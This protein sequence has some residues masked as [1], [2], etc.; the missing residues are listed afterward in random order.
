MIHIVIELL[1]L[2]EA[3]LTEHVAN[4]IV[5]HGQQVAQNEHVHE[6]LHLSI[7]LA[8]EFEGAK[9][10]FWRFVIG[11]PSLYVRDYEFLTYFNLL[12]H[13]GQILASNSNAATDRSLKSLFAIGEF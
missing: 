8:I 11:Q 12:A 4:E 1:P 7:L 5:L 10:Q 3:R 13:V 6:H 9:D 2:A